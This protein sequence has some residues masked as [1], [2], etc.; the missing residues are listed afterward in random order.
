MLKEKIEKH[1]T[2]SSYC[3][4]YDILSAIMREGFDAYLL[5][6]GEET[7]SKVNSFINGVK[8][9]DYAANIPSFL[10]FFDEVFDDSVSA[11]SMPMPLSL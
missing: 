6:K 1:R 9:K 11:P 2:M 4:V 8:G 7:I 10:Q 3:G 5:S